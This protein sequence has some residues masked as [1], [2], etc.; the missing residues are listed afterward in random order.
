MA[1]ES[2][3]PTEITSEQRMG[4]AGISRRRVFLLL[5][6]S[7]LLIITIAAAGFAFTTRSWEDNWRADIERNFTQKARMFA[8]DVNSD[9]T[10]NIATLTS[11]EGQLAGAR[12][13][14]I[15]MNGKVIADSEVRIADL[16]SEGRGPEFA[17]ALR[18]DTGID[19]RSRS[20]FGTPVLYVAV[21]VSG[22]AVRLAS[23]LADVTIASSHANRMLTV[24]CGIAIIAALAISAFASAAVVRRKAA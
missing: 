5:F 4:A 22:G 3:I 24:V 10:R 14:V 17:A 13:T 15:D 1:I 16:D 8:A 12:A 9:R 20:A 21:P 18:G 7:Y 11:Q 2:Q 6:S 19:V 23:P